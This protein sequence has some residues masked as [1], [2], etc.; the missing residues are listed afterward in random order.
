MAKPLFLMWYDDSPKVSLGHKID[1]A[2]EA[3]IDRFNLVPN[4]VLM[5]E[6]DLVEHTDIV[7]RGASNIRRNNFWVGLEEQVEG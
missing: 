4:I 1:A 3:Y 5:N 7:V 6:D 2:V